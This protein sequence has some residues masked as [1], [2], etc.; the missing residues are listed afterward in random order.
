MLPCSVLLALC[1]NNIG[2]WL[3]KVSACSRR[4]AGIVRGVGLVGALFLAVYVMVGVVVPLTYRF[5]ER[6]GFR[7]FAFFAGASVAVDLAHLQLGATGFAYVNYAFVW[8]KR[9]R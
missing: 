2:G 9:R 5:W 1:W 4:R 7:S 3:S 8:P 6:Y